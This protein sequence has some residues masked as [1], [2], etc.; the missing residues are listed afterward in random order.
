MTARRIHRSVTI[1]AAT[2]G[3]IALAGAAQ[4]SMLMTDSFEDG[5]QPQR[6]WPNVTG[7]WGGDL[8]S[9]VGA[10]QAITPRTGDGMMHFRSAGG[11]GPSGLS[12]DDLYRTIDLGSMRDAI[13]TGQVVLEASYYVNRVAG[14][15]QTDTQF[16]IGIRAFDGATNTFSRDV[17][18]PL[19]MERAFVQTDGDV[20]TWERVHVELT[21]PAETQY[22][23]VW[24]G[25]QENVFND[26]SGPGPE[27]DGHYGDD[28]SVH[29]RAVPSPSGLAMLATM[30]VITMRRRRCD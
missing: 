13:S 4:G 30:G 8:S 23:S 12:S 20:L 26:R 1:A 9:V 19:D 2:L 6:G 28:F 24:M 22:I 11:G 5:V 27:F 25:A 29:I 10:Q 3:V 7:R 17:R 16:G 14:D 15:A 18:S 21:L